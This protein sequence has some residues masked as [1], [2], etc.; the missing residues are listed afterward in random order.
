MTVFEDMM[1]RYGS[2]KL[3]I[4]NVLLENNIICNYENTGYIAYSGMDGYKYID[5][6]RRVDSVLPLTIDEVIRI[7]KVFTE[8]CTM[9]CK[10]ND[11]A[12][13]R[14]LQTYIDHLNSSASSTFPVTDFVNYLN[15]KVSDETENDNESGDIDEYM[16]DVTEI[17][18]KEFGEKYRS[19]ENVDELYNPLEVIN[20][21]GRRVVLAGYLLDYVFWTS[22]S[23][24]YDEVVRN[25]LFD[26]HGVEH[27]V[28]INHTPKITREDSIKIN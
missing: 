17:T 5:P 25:D 6:I 28:H 9:V 18:P 26:S 10:D 2:L 8:P 14:C 1:K 11:D 27:I 12:R 23:A 21:Q 22:D 3:V 15:N 20:S 19:I 4:A 7:S 13:N 24:V 16:P